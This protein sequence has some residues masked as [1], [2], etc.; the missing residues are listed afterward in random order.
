MVNAGDLNFEH[1]GQRIY[2]SASDAGKPDEDRKRE[3]AVRKLMRTVI[4]ANGN[5]GK[6]LKTEGTLWAN[7]RL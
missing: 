3:K 5:D 2:M 1:G 4:E 6:Q 7:Y